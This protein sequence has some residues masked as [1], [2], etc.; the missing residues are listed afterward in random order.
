MPGRLLRASLDLL[1]F[2]VSLLLSRVELGLLDGG[3]SLLELLLLS[4]FL[5]FASLFLRLL[6]ELLLL[7]QLLGLPLR[8]FESLGDR[9]V[10]CGVSY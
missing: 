8:L 1:G 9:V 5:S 10:I 6:P 4:L 7:S 3:L 2:F